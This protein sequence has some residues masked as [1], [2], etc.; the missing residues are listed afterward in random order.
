MHD[1]RINI[2]NANF[3]KR[4][5]DERIVRKNEW[6]HAVALLNRKLKFLEE[7]DG[8]FA[9]RLVVNLLEGEFHDLKKVEDRIVKELKEK[10]YN[11]VFKKKYNCSSVWNYNYWM[12]IIIAEEE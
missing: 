4:M 8:Y 1:T 3:M 10:G 12:E 9:D 5:I 11:T 2:V 7:I 6:E